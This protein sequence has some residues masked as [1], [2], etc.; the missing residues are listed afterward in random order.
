MFRTPLCML[1]VLIISNYSYGIS[2]FVAS[3]YSPDEGLE[4]VVIN[5]P[6]G[7]ITGTEKT[8]TIPA[9]IAVITW[10]VTGRSD[11][12]SGRSGQL[13]PVIGDQSP[14][15]GMFM[16]Y[17]QGLRGS[18]SG[19]WS[20]PTPGGEVIVRLRVGNVQGSFTF[21]SGNNPVSWTLTVYPDS[22]TLE[23]QDGSSQHNPLPDG[24]ACEDG[25]FCTMDDSCSAGVCVSGPVNPLCIGPPGSDGLPGADGAAGASG[26]PGATGSQGAA[27][28][29]GSAGAAGISC[30][31]TNGDGV[32]SVD[33]DINEDGNFNALDCVGATGPEGERGPAGLSCW[34]LNGNGVGDP[35]EDTNADGDFDALDCQGRTGRPCENDE[36]CQDGLFCNGTEICDNNVCAN[37]SLPCDLENDTC[38]E[39]VD[40]CVPADLPAGQAVVPDGSGQPSSSLCGAMSSVTMIMMFLGF[41]SLRATRFCS[42]KRAVKHARA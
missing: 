27:G 29:A 11:S 8:L 9:G 24:T 37:G 14:T 38:L 21:G 10:T 17:A 16:N 42:T 4:T 6:S 13:I 41:V 15:V 36:D 5:Q 18:F 32:G 7:D 39:D 20:T 26:Q 1:L 34:D 31:D 30:W 23:C 12:A 22:T 40:R 25:F 3:F 28:T 19:T 35:D 2:P 33:E